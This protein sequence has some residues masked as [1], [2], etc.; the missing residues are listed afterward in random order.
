[1]NQTLQPT[2]LLFYSTNIL[3][4][5]IEKIHSFLPLNLR[6][7]QQLC[8]ICAC[9]F[10]HVRISKFVSVKQKQNFAKTNTITC[11]LWLIQFLSFKSKQDQ[12]KTIS[13]SCSVGLIEQVLRLVGRQ[14]F[15]YFDNFFEFIFVLSRNG[16]FLISFNHDQKMYSG[17]SLK[18]TTLGP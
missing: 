15:L 5:H 13:G 4:L 2:I 18:W 12:A 9:K 1:M 8:K 14:C 17:I 3:L 10:F 11:V 6:L 7:K 16:V